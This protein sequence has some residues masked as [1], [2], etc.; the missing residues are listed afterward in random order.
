[1]D[2]LLVVG[3]G[4]REHALG[5]Q[6]R[7]DVPKLYFAPGNAGTETIGENVNISQVDIPR[8]VDFA[9]QNKVDMVVVGPDDAL[10]VGLVDTLQERGIPAF[11]PT[12]KAASIE[13]SKNYSRALMLE[14]KVPTAE[15]KSFTT[16]EETLKYLAA[17]ALPCVVK[18]DDL[19]L[20]KGVFVCDRL[21]AAESAVYNLLVKKNLGQAEAGKKI[22]IESFVDGPELSLHALCDGQNY[23][24]LPPVRDYKTLNGKIM[25]GSM[26]AFGPV[27]GISDSETTSYGEK[28]VAPLL[29][30]SSDKD[31][32]F[33]GLL[34][35]VLKGFSECEKML[36]VNA[37]WGD[38]ETQVH[39]RRLKNSLLNSLVACIDGD[40]RKAPPE[41]SDQYVVCGVIAAE[42][43]PGIP[44]KDDVIE[45]LDD[46][47]DLDGVVV[48]HAGTK[49]KGK[50]IVTN[51]GKVLS[52]TVAADTLEEAHI[53]LY[54]AIDRIRFRGMQL[55]RD[56]GKVAVQY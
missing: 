36:E 25:T 40:I 55:R 47:D 56:I 42:G 10:A 22:L 2:R 27:P 15:Y 33:H 32:P 4:G 24:M 53:K 19:S 45:G 50:D 49:R 28:F 30:A 18:A 21:T 43:Y 35:P 12:K 6:L 31:A 41:W 23:V 5:W 20:G 37:C 14:A 46:V 8:L 9:Y 16:Y 38:P 11:G 3:G 34:F 44:V 29:K 39:M 26:G 1:M 7:N 54:G 48:F 52:V 51:G 17:I 13:S